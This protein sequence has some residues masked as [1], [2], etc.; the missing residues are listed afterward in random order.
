MKR[1]LFAVLLGVSILYSA[2]EDKRKIELEIQLRQTEKEVALRQ[3]RLERAEEE[4][5]AAIAELETTIAE[6]NQTRQKLDVATKIDSYL[7]QVRYLHLADADKYP[8]TQELLT[9]LNGIKSPNGAISI[10]G[11]RH[12]ISITDYTYILYQAQRIIDA[13][14]IAPRQF[15]VKMAIIHLRNSDD[16]QAIENDSKVKSLDE[17]L[18]TIK[19]DRRFGII[20]EPS[21]LILEDMEG[22][23]FIGAQD[24][25]GKKTGLSMSILI[26]PDKDNIKL[27][28]KIEDSQ[29]SPS[30]LFETD[31]PIELDKVISL[32][33]GKMSNY[34]YLLAVT[35]FKSQ[36]GK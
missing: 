28:A 17:L 10:D 5:K 23:L 15:L 12:T 25:T 4:L 31:M 22:T 1:I 6:L 34:F 26:K 9:K 27:S 7:F 19:N 13:L 3:A 2:C 33:D 35:E 24:E 21:L 8:K 36:E 32:P 20:Q 29:K 16:R 11:R 18:I 14:D 30:L